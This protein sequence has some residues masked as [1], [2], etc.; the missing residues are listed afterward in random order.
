MEAKENILRCIRFENPD[1]IPMNFAI[2]AASWHHYEQEALKDLL[3]AHPLLFPGYKRTPGKVLPQYALNAIAS[4]PY[5][6]QWS[7]VWETADDGITGSVH[8]HPLESWDDFANYKAPDPEHSN[9]TY[10]VD[11]KNIGKWVASSKAA[12]EIVCLGLPHGHTY[13][14]L[15][16]IRGYEDLTVDMAEEHPLL[17]KLIGMVSDFNYAL[18][19]KYLS[20]KPDIFGYAEDLGMQVGPMISPEHFRKYI[21]PVYKRLMK[22]ALDNGCIVQM[23][24]DGDIRTLADELVDAGVQVLNLQDLVN[25]IDW[26]AAKFSGKICIELDIDRQNITPFGTPQQIDNM[27]REEV[28]KLGSRKGGL[29]MVYGLYPGVPLEN[30]KALMDS[31]EK[32]MGYYN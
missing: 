25:G 9:G 1:W 19:E 26:I 24:S 12:G 17:P 4:K 8:K 20:L 18:V 32:H 29:M 6:D 2:N 21:K 11:W 27:I 15:Q 22:P 3:E 13:L 28:Q 23:H 10:A 30:V 16:D 5:T 7:C 14:R 31:M